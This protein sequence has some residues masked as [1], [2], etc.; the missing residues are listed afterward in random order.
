MAAEDLLL[1]P[2]VKKYASCNYLPSKTVW[3]RQSQI[4]RMSRAVTLTEP[5]TLFSPNNKMVW[6]N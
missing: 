6:E 2:G 1:L 5:V 3:I 4:N